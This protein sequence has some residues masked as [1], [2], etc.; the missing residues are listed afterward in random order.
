MIRTACTRRAVKVPVT[1]WIPTAN[2]LEG[3]ELY[4]GPAT[5]QKLYSVFTRCLYA[6]WFEFF[7]LRTRQIAADLLSESYELFLSDCGEVLL[8]WL[9]TFS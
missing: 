2:L 1:C 3:S 4:M 8:K 9:E 6:S 5:A 7:V